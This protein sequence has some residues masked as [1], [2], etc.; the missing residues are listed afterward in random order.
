MGLVCR[1]NHLRL[2]GSLLALTLAC[3]LQAQ[4]PIDGKVKA[5]V[6]GRIGAII[7]RR[8][9]VPGV[10]FGK[11]PEFLKEEKADIDAAKSEEE[12]QTAVNQAL[13]K[14]GASHVLLMTPH[15]DQV[16][17]TGKT[18]GIGIGAR[19]VP[20]GLLVSRV[21]R[22]APAAKAGI[23]QGDVI[24]AIDGKPIDGLRGLKGDE[25]TDVSVKVLHP[26]GKA[27]EYKL[28]RQS[29]K[30][31]WPPEL[32]WI[33][34]DTACLRIY[35]FD[36]G[37]D[38][39][40]VEELVDEAQDAKNLILDLR[41]NGGGAVS[42]LQHLLGMLIP[43]GRPL[44]C[45]IDR[46]TVARYVQD[47]GGKSTDLAA[48][49]QWSND[50][51][52]PI[53]RDDRPFFAG[54]VAVLVNRFSGSAS[55][56]GASALHDVLGAPVIGSKTAGAVLASTIVPATNDFAI[57]IPI[58]DYITIK[59]VRLEGAGV[60]PD[61]DAPDASVAPRDSKDPAIEKACFYFTQMS[62]G[63]R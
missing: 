57:Q 8:A 52:V 17:R 29:Y 26:D 19:V 20:E 47:T 22:D 61:I 46:S 41:G 51:F 35:A 3:L 5:E 24:V 33:D 56:I 16:R 62:K 6:L 10:D 49:A 2:T 7:S 9:F 48:I 11:W 55:E 34:K 31:V 30:T 39:N 32:S 58:E 23:S 12:F 50:K 59:G 14:F 40:L 27:A 43:K 1:F 63:S 18:V 60:V 36:T 37:Y 4:A 42:N 54:N 15:I 38:R 45:F 13:H 21:Y 25:G 44:G 28:T 53:F